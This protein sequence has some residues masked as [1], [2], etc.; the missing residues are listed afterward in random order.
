MT[1]STVNYYFL[2]NMNRK[3]IIW[4]L[5]VRFLFLHLPQISF[6]L[7]LFDKNLMI[8]FCFG[9]FTCSDVYGIKVP[10]T[11]SHNIMYCP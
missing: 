6:V 5:S 3:Y 2:V 8:Y 9:S 11:A 10:K 7:P 4:Y 1:R